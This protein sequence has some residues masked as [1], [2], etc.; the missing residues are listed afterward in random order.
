MYRI[1]GTDLTEI[2]GISVLT[3]HVFF[4]EVGPDISKFSTA[5]H[6]CSWL[7]LNPSNKISGGKVLSS[8]TR[9]GSN[10]AAQAIRLAALAL[11]NSQSYLGHYYRRMR[12]RHGAPK[13]IT[14]TAHKLARIIYYLV[15]TGKQF[16]ESV[17]AEQEELHKI[18]LERNLKKQAKYLGF[19]LVPA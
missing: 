4:T 1:L 6:F 3:S 19:Q 17:F 10:R 13:A 5:K 18:R 7:G 12:A 11:W 9:P 8:K 14:A 16:D 15:K 2:D